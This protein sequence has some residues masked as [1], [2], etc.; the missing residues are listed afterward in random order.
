[1]SRCLVLRPVE[2]TRKETRCDTARGGVKAYLDR[3]SKYFD[4]ILAE[5]PRVTVWDPYPYF[6]DNRKC[7]S[8]TDRKPLYGDDAHLCKLGSEYFARKDA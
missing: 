1:M 8:T 6:C 5:E 7:I 2:N 3:H 4:R